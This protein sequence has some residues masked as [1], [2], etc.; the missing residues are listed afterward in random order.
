VNTSTGSGGTGFGGVRLGNGNRALWLGAVTSS[1][2][3]ELIGINNG[4]PMS[5]W[6]DGQTASIPNN[7]PQIIA[8]EYEESKMNIFLNGE[9]KTV[10]PRGG[11]HASPFE[12]DEF[13]FGLP[14]GSTNFLNGHVGEFMVFDESIGDDFEKVHSYLAKKWGITSTVDSDN[15]GVVDA[16]D[17][18]P[19]D[20]TK[21]IDAPDFSEAVGAII[22]TDNADATGL[23]TVEGDL[24]LWLDAANIDGQSNASFSNGDTISTWMDLSGNNHHALKEAG[25]PSYESSNNLIAFDGTSDYF[26]SSVNIDSVDMPKV[27][28]LRY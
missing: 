4:V 8:V 10:S 3:Y 28:I 11:N 25:A 13:Q 12:I 19:V 23:A 2:S 20:A 22:N 6:L 17:A 18:Y 21:A 9:L 1:Y 14:S 24:A 27:T 7:V 15:D 26:I 5:G 16:S